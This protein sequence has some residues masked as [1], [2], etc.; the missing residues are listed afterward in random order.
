MET[1]VLDYLKNSGLTSPTADH[2]WKVTGE[3]ILF[4]SCVV[5]ER[6]EQQARRRQKKKNIR[7]QG[8]AAGGLARAICRLPL[9]QI[10]LGRPSQFA[11]AKDPRAVLT[12][13]NAGLPA[14]LPGGPRARARG[15]GNPLRRDRR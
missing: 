1:V 8:L 11:R 3:T 10:A 7:R 14:E 6:N 13:G 2:S 4:F 12:Q 5:P 15:P 9:L